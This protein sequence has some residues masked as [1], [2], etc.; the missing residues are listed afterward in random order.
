MDKYVLKLKHIKQGY[1]TEY[2]C[3]DIHATWCGQGTSRVGLGLLPW[4]PLPGQLPSP[5]KTVGL[6]IR[7][8][9]SLIKDVM[10]FLLSF[11]WTFR[12]L[13]FFS[14]CVFFPGYYYT[15]INQCTM[16]SFP[17]SILL[18]SFCLLLRVPSCLLS[19]LLGHHGGQ[20]AGHLDIPA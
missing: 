12:S 16:C 19:L 10:L 4:G 18:G 14:W 13:L 11:R 15:M 7:D 1:V 5:A 3:P 6:Q 17:I 2:K 8:E 9:L 20:V